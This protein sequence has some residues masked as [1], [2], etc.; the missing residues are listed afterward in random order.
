[1][2]KRNSDERQKR[3]SDR[4]NVFVKKY[5]RKAQPGRDPNDRDYDRKLEER[6]RRMKPEVLDRLLRNGDET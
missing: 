4:L 5:A 2:K 6:I 1:M 3:Q